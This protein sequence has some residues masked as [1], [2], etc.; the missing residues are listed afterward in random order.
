MISSR[1][2]IQTE[3]NQDFKEKQKIL[4]G[5]IG[6]MGYSMAKK[7][8]KKKIPFTRNKKHARKEGVLQM[9]EKI[10]IGD[11]VITDKKQIAAIL[12]SSS[13]KNETK[14]NCGVEYGA[15]RN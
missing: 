12:N 15:K 8:N 14:D 11:K 5:L 2:R 4:S 7:P 1:G 6:E 3:T 13:T 10:W 9:P